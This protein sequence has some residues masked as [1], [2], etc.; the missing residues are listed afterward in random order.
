[1]QPP[2]HLLALSAFGVSCLLLVSNVTAERAKEP[3]PDWAVTAAKTP[4]PS[5]AKDAP[6]V[7]LF[8]E[9][10]ITVDAQNHAVERERSAVR[11]LKPQG[12][13][14]ADCAA[15]YDIDSKLDY[16][17]S[18][19]ITADGRQLQAMEPDFTD[20]G[21]YED[22][23]MQMTERVRRAKS[24]AS[25]PGNVVICETEVRYRP[26]MSEE[27]WNIQQSIPIVSEALELDLAPGGHF[28]A[29][30]RKLPPIKPI[31]VGPNRIRWEIKD[32]PALDLEN[33][34]ATPGWEALAARM[35]VKWGDDAVEGKDNQWRAVGQWTTSLE[36][37]RPDPT[38]EITAKAQ[39]LTAG[40]TDFYTK[41]SRIADFV[42]K[43]IRY[44]IVMRGIGGWQAH[45]AADIYRKH[46]GDC[47]DKATIAIS[48]LQAV[49]I[50]AVYMPVDTTR[51]V[52][53]P[54]E[55]SITGNHMIAAIEI[56]PDVND[57]RLMAVA[58]AKDGKRYLIFDPTNEHTAIGNLP[59]YLQ[60]GYGTLAA[61]PASQ[62]LALP[63]LQP[64]ASG[65]EQK[66]LFTLSADG[67]LTGSVDAFHS[68]SEGAEFREFLKE[69][70]DKERREVWEHYVASSLP[71][72]TLDAFQ[73]TQP[74]ALDKP[75]E[76]HYKVTAGQY[77]HNAGP[78]MLVR[79][80]VIGSYSRSFDSKPRTLPINLVATGHWHDSYDITLPPGYVVDEMPDP[81]SIDLDFASYHSS[82][83][84]KGNQ[85]HYDREY[86]VRQVELPPDKAD[87]FRRLESAIVA[88]ERG[89]AVLKKQ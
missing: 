74:T 70:D 60:G 1:M 81:A 5:N 20:Y 84:V 88:D 47:K 21:A 64:D 87:D 65:T 35:S 36:E 85:L 28:A 6:A 12:R 45:P 24:P 58:K 83:S 76:F 34:H 86:I 7:I 75:L 77:A 79:P 51:G 69:T 68:G 82:I 53:D 78:L 89:T 67:T 54:D 19:T 4:T 55:P 33:L 3:A 31:E 42:Q 44:F 8:D 16:I 56:P 29:A 57:P 2:R 63:V 11:I 15:W 22:P 23:V 10:L 18:W 17:R 39:E 41:L 46:Y 38:P 61:G 9:Y 26:Y 66:G 72:V 37:H 25:D 62:V 52:V 49:G 59:Y 27:E 48:M 30:W 80:R 14:H 32:M 40:A 73:F 50:H 71:G 43:N 13:R